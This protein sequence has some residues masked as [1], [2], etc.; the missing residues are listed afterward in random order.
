MYNAN[1]MGVLFKGI[2]TTSLVLK[3]NSYAKRKKGKDRLT[4]LMCSC[5]DGTNLIYTW[6]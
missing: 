5:M 3:S 4:V 2:P 1:E 6:P